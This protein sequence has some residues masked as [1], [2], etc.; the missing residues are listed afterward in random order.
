MKLSK[1]CVPE[2]FKV[3]RKE[4]GRKLDCVI[5]N[6]K[7][8]FSGKEYTRFNVGINGWTEWSFIAYYDEQD[9]NEHF[10]VM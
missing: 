2:A 3:I 5:Q 9:F 1:G 10:D 4:D 6:F 8:A 7:D